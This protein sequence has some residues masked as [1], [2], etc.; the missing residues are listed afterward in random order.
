MQGNG[1]PPPDDGG[2]NGMDNGMV[3]FAR[4]LQP[5]FGSI[6]TT[7]HTVGGAADLAGIDLNLTSDVAYAMLV[8]QPSSQQPG[9]M[10][11]VPGDAEASYLFVKIS[12]A[13]PPVGLRMHTRFWRA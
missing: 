11:V 3:S 7:C 9:S 4:D 1:G 10:F 6:C 5:I 2:D 8:N 12:E 13:S